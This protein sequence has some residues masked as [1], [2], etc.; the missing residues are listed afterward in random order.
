MSGNLAKTLGLP[1]VDQVAWLVNDIDEALKTFGPLFGEFSRMESV[2]EGSNYRG[3]K[4]DMK[5]D[6]AFGKS[7]D[8]EI[9][10]IAVL[11]GEGPHKE[12]LDSRGEGVH[13]VR[14]R[15]DEIGEPQR[16]LEALGFKPI[17]QHG[18][19]E[20]NIAWAYFEGPAEQ[21]GAIVELLQM[22]A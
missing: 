13:H 18:M 6:I 16:K 11:E 8:L 15:V 7:G 1:P 20:M 5:L 14:F 10:L 2:I 19:P 9:E 22:P 21:G 4:T 12:I 3:R 17:W